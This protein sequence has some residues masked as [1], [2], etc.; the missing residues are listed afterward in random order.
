MPLWISPQRRIRFTPRW[1]HDRPRAHDRRA[2]SHAGAARRGRPRRRRHGRDALRARGSAP[3]QRARTCRRAR[4]A[5]RRGAHC[6]RRHRGDHRLR[7][8]AAVLRRPHRRRDIDQFADPVFIARDGVPELS[9]VML[10]DREVRELVERMLQH[11]GRRVDLSNLPVDISVI[12]SFPDFAAQLRPAA[13]RRWVCGLPVR[14][15]RRRA[16]RN[17]FAIAGD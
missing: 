14:S 5:G 1:T 16:R 11:S 4:T 13:R 17:L 10:S 9:T 7:A 15:R 2:G 3:L 8:A 6:A 12:R